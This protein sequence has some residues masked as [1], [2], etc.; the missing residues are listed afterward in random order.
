MNTIIVKADN[1]ITKALVSIFEAFG[2]NFEVKKDKQDQESPYDPEF[3]AMV[4]KRSSNAKKGEA[5]E[6]TEEL[7]NKI[8][9][10]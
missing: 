10:P 5:V 6:Y 7:K 8:F 4:L 1:K 9:R 2:V 3:V